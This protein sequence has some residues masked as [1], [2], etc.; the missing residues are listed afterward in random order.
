M[1][2]I[3]NKRILTPAR[4]PRCGR[5]RIRQALPRPTFP[6]SPRVRPYWR[7]RTQ[8]LVDMANSGLQVSSTGLVVSSTGLVV[9]D[10]STG[11]T[12]CCGSTGTPCG[13]CV[14]STPASWVFT[15]SSVALG[16]SCI[17]DGGGGHS[18][19]ITS[20]TTFSGT[21]TLF[22]TPGLPCQWELY[23]SYSLA[24]AEKWG[25][26]ITCSGSSTYATD[27]LYIFATMSFGGVFSI[28]ASLIKRDVSLSW[29]FG[30][31]LFG[32]GY[33]AFTCA[34]PFTGL[35]NNQTSFVYAGGNPGTEV[36][37]GKNGTVDVTPV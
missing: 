9:T 27:E 35:T 26:S 6:R 7:S 21:F 4:C 2:L 1:L 5:L 31:S 19:K 3:P 10:A 14:D 29:L 36:T 25:T 11:A 24:V 30:A 12:C 34:T 33:V 20:G 13:F 37:L 22:Q 17:N 15:F 32:G 28:G 16:T 23:T 18:A 8:E